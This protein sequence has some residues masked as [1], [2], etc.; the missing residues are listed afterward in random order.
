MSPKKPIGI[1]RRNIHA[2]AERDGEMR[3]IAADAQPLLIGLIGGARG[4]GILIAKG[5]MIA[6]K[7]ANRL[8]P[9]PAARRRSEQLPGNIAELVG[10]AIAAAEH[11]NERVIRQPFDRDLFGIE[12]D[13]VGLA[14]NLDDG[15]AANGQ[16]ARRRH[17]PADTIAECIEIN[18]R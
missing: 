2:A 13:R 17:K 1:T 12:L 3:E 16:I 9:A 4:A 7:I 10:F 6:D 15:I 8:D 18:L 5:Q 14:A 11:E